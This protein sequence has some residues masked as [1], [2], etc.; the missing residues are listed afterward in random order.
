MKYIK[1]L[2]PFIFVCSMTSCSIVTFPA[3]MKAYSEKKMQDKYLGMT[4]DELVD[5]FGRQPKEIKSNNG[6]EIYVYHIDVEMLNL[7]TNEVEVYRTK[8]PINFT[9]N[10][11]GRVSKIENKN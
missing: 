8:K 1:F 4:S 11:Q 10:D 3:K 9:F 5:S 6:N 2:L 7:D